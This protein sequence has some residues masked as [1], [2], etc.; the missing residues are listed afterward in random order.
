MS[1]DMRDDENITADTEAREETIAGQEEIYLEETEEEVRAI[2]ISCDP[3]PEPNPDP[4]LANQFGEQDLDSGARSMSDADSEA[5]TVDN[6]DEQL[7]G[8]TE[9]LIDGDAD[10]PPLSEEAIAEMLRVSRLRNSGSL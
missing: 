7:A 2:L 1:I 10:D 5:C 6:R 3:L 8:A 9:E 4:T